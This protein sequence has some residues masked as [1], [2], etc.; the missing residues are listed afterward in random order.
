M[1]KVLI[2]GGTGE[3]RRLAE[4]LAGRCDVVTSLAGRTTAPATLPGRVRTGGFG[5]AEGLSA[6]LR[7]EGIAHLIDATHPYAARMGANAAA[8]AAETGIPLVRLER[9]AWLPRD[10]DDWHCF[11]TVS[12]LAARLP[13]LGQHAL[14]TLGG[15]DLAAFRGLAGIRLTV[16][17]IDPPAHLEP[18]PNVAI[19][20]ARGPFD[21]AG[22]C[23]LLSDRGIDVVVSRN[24]G[25]TATRPK[26]DA[27]RELGL[28]VVMLNRPARPAVPVETEI[29][30]VLRRIGYAPPS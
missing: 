10:G 4:A 23:A 17:A 7:A 22:E 13:S 6:Y 26:I 30:S 8:A 28:P 20:L 3:A 15:A 12:D 16:R 19:L 14:I 18:G 24:A 9:P 25:G 11:D 2:L 27:A 29:D 21:L 5:G 1:R